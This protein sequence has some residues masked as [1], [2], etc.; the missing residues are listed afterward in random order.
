[1]RYRV[2]ILMIFA[3]LNAFAQVQKKTL[4]HDPLTKLYV[5]QYDTL[6]GG[7][8]YEMLGQDPYYV[9]IIKFDTYYKGGDIVAFMDKVLTFVRSVEPKTH[10]YI[11]G[12]KVT[13]YKKTITLQMEGQTG[14]RAIMIRKFEKIRDK[15][16]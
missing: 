5:N 10:A 6:G 1:M 14:Y 13:A 2:L 16:H 11:D 8:S 4:Y 9:K 7:K 3:G 15:C 12:V